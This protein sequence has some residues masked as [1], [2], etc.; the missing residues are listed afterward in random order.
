MASVT[1]VG[2]LPAPDLSDSTEVW[3]DKAPLLANLIIFWGRTARVCDDSGRGVFVGCFGA[4]RII[5]LVLV[6]VVVKVY[7]PYKLYEETTVNG[8]PSPEADF[9]H[10]VIGGAVWTM[11]VF[12]AERDILCDIWWLCVTVRM[13]GKQRACTQFNELFHLKELVAYVVSLAYDVGSGVIFGLCTWNLMRASL[14]VID[15]A[16]DCAA[17]TAIL[18]VDEII[19]EHLTF[20]FRGGQVRFINPYHIFK[21]SD[22]KEIIAAA[23]LAVIITHGILSVA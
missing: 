8:T 3:F 21:R 18:F 12:Q 11:V 10:L 4:I 15:K 14:T 5:G 13:R 19:Y 23:D 20:D 2:P 7:I 17:L 6:L 16:K 1:E 9:A 22:A